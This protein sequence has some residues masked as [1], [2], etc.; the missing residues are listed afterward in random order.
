[1]GSFNGECG[2]LINAM[3]GF[4]C[5]AMWGLIDSAL[6]MCEATLLNKTYILRHISI[7]YHVIVKIKGQHL[8]FIIRLQH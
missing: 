3:W 8:R 2:A 7:E 6:S 5:M 4:H 1:M